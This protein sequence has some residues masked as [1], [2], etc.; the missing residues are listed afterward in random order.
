MANE[1]NKALIGDDAKKLIIVYKD[2][3]K[4]G[5]CINTKEFAKLV[6]TDQGTISKMMNG[7]YPV[8][9]PVIKKICFDLKY[10]PAWLINSEGKPKADKE[11]VKL[12]TE[13]SM[14]RTEI[15]IW[16]G[17]VKRLEARVGIG[18]EDKK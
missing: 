15:D 13:I 18:N 3:K 2:C 16:A 11:G 14:L 1:K 9:Y 8:T 5:L 6:G 10:S 7:K 12:V 4:A 17:R